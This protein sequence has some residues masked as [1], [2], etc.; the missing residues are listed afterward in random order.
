MRRQDR[1]AF[2]TRT[3]PHS[4]V[5]SIGAAIVFAMAALSAIPAEAQ[6][7]PTAVYH[8]GP[9][10]SSPNVFLLFWG[11][12]F[13]TQERTNAA[14]YMIGLLQFFSGA[15]IPSGQ[16]PTIRQYGV[17][18][19]VYAGAFWD[20]STPPD[21]SDA[22]LQN[23]IANLQAAHSVPAY[24][25]ELIIL[26]V[27]KDVPVC[28]AY[29]H[30]VAWGQYYGFVPYQGCFG[31]PAEYMYQSFG[32]HE[33]MEFATDPLVTGGWYWDPP[34]N[35]EIVDFDGGGIVPACDQNDTITFPNNF[36][37]QL[38]PVLDNLQQ[39]CSTKTLQQASQISVASWASNRIDLAALGSDF[40]V[41]HKSWN[42]TAWSPS[43]TTWE[44]LGSPGPF[45]FS[46]PPTITSWG[47]NRLD[48]FAQRD[49]GGF[50]YHKAWTGTAWSTSWELLG[51][52]TTN[53]PFTGGTFAVTS[54]GPNRIDI[55]GQGGDGVYYH[56]AWTGSA[57]VPAASAN[58]ESLGGGFIG[59]PAAVS[60][61]S[62]RV[63]VFGEGLD[64]AYY[65]RSYDGSQWSNGWEG[66]GGS[67]I[68]PPVAI[69]WGI[70]RIDVFGQTLDGTYL[71][72]SFNGTAWSPSQ[73]DWERLDGGFLGP[74]A[75][76]AWGF[77]HLDIVGQGLDGAYYRKTWNGTSWSSSWQQL[78]GGA[79]LSAPAMVARA[80]NRLDIFGRGLDAGAWHKAWTG[81]AWSPSTV[82]EN[83]GGS[84]H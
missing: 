31:H 78:Q 11:P 29:H 3:N 48:V 82:Y 43:K 64:G 51:S 18:G 57:W 26:V 42:G 41:W 53:I 39:T 36:V 67:F 62:N 37:G 69:S 52:P 70:N 7:P 13:T 6:V 23:K 47:T 15:G 8:N 45:K 75:A 20:T 24:A 46:A 35:H 58:W 79:F 33:V 76:S 59:P 10:A 81:T 4:G 56:K 5:R 54:W 44:S 28:G 77:N 72:K 63:D 50:C 40:A 2:A 66:I 14:L 25:P 30:A 32:A 61:A 22:T 83:L 19:G 21:S 38:P 55:V 49:P 12:S 1:A 84:I 73:T 17:Y 65:H 68:G 34:G 60:W 80:S 9:V 16:E 74:P 71:H 27:S